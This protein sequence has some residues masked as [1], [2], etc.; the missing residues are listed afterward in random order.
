MSY[1]QLTV[2]LCATQKGG[3][4]KTTI[5]DV[6]HA[7]STA[8]GLDTLVVDVDDGNSGF[9]RRSGKA[10]PSPWNGSLNPLKHMLGRNATSPARISLFSIWVQTSSP[11]S[12]R[13]L[14]FSE[15]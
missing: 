8:A 3:A 12:R 14:S 9:Q 4:G 11:V 2:L 7:V 6:S 5:A 13:S 15:C 10:R 1:K